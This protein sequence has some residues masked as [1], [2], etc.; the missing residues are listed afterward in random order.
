M[1]NLDSCSKNLTVGNQSQFYLPSTMV[2]YSSFRSFL[3][4]QPTVQSKEEL[5]MQQLLGMQLTIS[6]INMSMFTVSNK[7]LFQNWNTPRTWEG[8]FDSEIGRYEIARAFQ[9]LQSISNQ[10]YTIYPLENEI[11]R[12]FELCPRDK[13]KVV[14]LGQDPYPSM[15]DIVNLPMACGLSFSGR[16][17]G[18]KPGSLDNVFTEIRR[19]FPGIHLDH[20]DL[21]SWCTQGVLLLNSSLTVNHGDPNSHA[22]EKVWNYF[23]EYVI[24]TISEENHGVIFC[25]WGGSAKAYNSGSTKIIT[26]KSIVLECGHPSSR[27]MSASKF[28]ENNHFAYIYYYI[29][30][31]NQEIQKKNIEL[32]AQS[33][34][35]LPFKEQINWTLV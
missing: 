6:N 29:E 12:A 13:I 19:T 34:P 8:I 3:D 28:S 9:K 20:Y 25:L 16:K 18:K 26:S 35:L 23:I 21:T 17:G 10:G 2:Q 4:E 24:K 1:S 32:Q 5:Y 27:N 14:I 11:F 33:K 30:K 7:S 15:D 22:K 31:Y